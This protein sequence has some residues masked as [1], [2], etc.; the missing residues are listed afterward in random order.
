MT[1]HF[2]PAFLGTTIFLHVLSDWFHYLKI[3][4]TQENVNKHHVLGFA[5]LLHQLLLAQMLAQMLAGGAQAG[6]W[7][8]M[9]PMERFTPKP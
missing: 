1:E 6:L 8:K 9:D 5:M 2:F 7:F 3:F 4:L